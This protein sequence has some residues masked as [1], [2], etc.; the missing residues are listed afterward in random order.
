MPCSPA[1]QAKGNDA[2]RGLDGFPSGLTPQCGVCFVGWLANSPLLAAPP[3][4]HPSALHRQRVGELKGDTPWGQPL[5]TLPSPWCRACD[6]RKK[7]KPAG[8]GLLL[9]KSA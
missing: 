6:G 1:T 4:A 9:V 3:F 7:N 8:A 5:K 2:M